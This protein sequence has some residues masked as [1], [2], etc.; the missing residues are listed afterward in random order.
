M[1]YEGF[2]AYVGRIETEA[3]T[4]SKARQ[5]IRYRLYSEHHWRWYDAMHADVEPVRPVK[6]PTRN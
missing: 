1:T 6:V 2:A 3:T 4:V 5:N